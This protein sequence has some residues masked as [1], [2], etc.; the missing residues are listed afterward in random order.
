MAN[1]AFIVGSLWEAPHGSRL[2][3]RPNDSAENNT[4]GAPYSGVTR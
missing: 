4:G 1:R 3:C 2:V